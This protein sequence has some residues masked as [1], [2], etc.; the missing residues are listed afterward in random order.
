M[1]SVLFPELAWML[2]YVLLVPGVIAAAGIAAAATIGTG[3]YSASQQSKA[4]KEASQTQAESADAATQLQREMWQQQ[5]QDIAPWRQAGVQALGGLQRMIR[6]GPGAPFRAPP[7]LDPRRFKFTPPTAE[8]LQQ[9][10]GFAF[11]LRMGQQA[12]EGSAAQ[13]GGL[14]SGG[15]LR[16]LVDLGQQL[17]SQ[18]Y[19]QAYGRALS[20][21]QLG[22]GRALTQNQDRYN[23][24]LSSWQLGQGLNQAQ[25][26][27]LSSLAGLGQQSSQYLGQLGANYAQNAGELA[28]QRG[29][30]LAANQLNQGQIW[31]NVAQSAASGLGSLGMAYMQRPPASPAQAGYGQPY[32][33]VPYGQWDY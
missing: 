29:N 28:L 21:N 15:T 33:G 13:R 11:R 3:V 8:T 1:L 24:A 16:G 32:G 30:A 18:E 20:E 25:Y 14:L 22:Y 12:L 27:R 23:R 6:Q 26:N 2:P 7:G 31:G 10:P 19:Q 5:R 4:S 9:D 17:G